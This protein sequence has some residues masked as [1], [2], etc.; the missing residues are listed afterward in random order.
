MGWL[1]KKPDDQVEQNLI[2]AVLVST[3]NSLDRE[4][5]IVNTSGKVLFATEKIQLL[6][7]INEGK[8]VLFKK[9]DNTENAHWIFA[10]RIIGNNKSI[11]DTT[12]FF[13]IN[14]VDIRPFFYPIHKHSHLINIKNDDKIS[15]LLNKEIIMIPSSPSITIE[16]QSYIV[17]IIEKF[18]LS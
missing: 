9:E 14:N 16:E 10:I 3:L 15:E 13:K 1:N 6:N 17:R 8:I 5:I 11:E 12:E 7:L 2:P 4:S 18:I